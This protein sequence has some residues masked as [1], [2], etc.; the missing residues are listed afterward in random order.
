MKKWAFLGVI[1]HTGGTWTVFENLRAGLAQHGIELRWVVAGQR[2]FN[3]LHG[4][5]VGNAGEVVAMDERDERKIAQQL[6]THLQTKYDGTI[7]NVLCDRLCINV[8]QYLPASFRR[9]MLVHNITVGTYKAARSIRDYV[10]GS[11]GVSQRITDDLIQKY[12][13]NPAHTFTIHNAVPVERFDTKP[14]RQSRRL[15]I[16]VLSRIENQSKGSFHIPRILQQLKQLH[17][18]YTCT[19]IGD[20]P[21]LSELKRRC[22]GLKVHFTGRIPSHRV[23]HAVA[24]HDV[25]LFPSIYEGF[26]LSLIE[27]MAGG[28]V[29]VASLLNGVTD[30]I[31]TNRKSGFLISPSDT[32]GFAHALKALFEQPDLKKQMSC[33]AQTRIRE[34][35][36]V[37]AISARFSDLI[38]KVDQS[39]RQL[40]GTIKSL[41]HWCYSRGLRTGLRSMFPESFK[42]HLRLLREKFFWLSYS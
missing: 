28:C 8:I 18:P 23:P 27:A 17:V 6:A 35:F 30:E 38:D 32:H 11:I 31:V 37:N 15:R 26:G 21:D 10:H 22:A 39:P 16:L 40:P 9:L 13:F 42:S 20:G 29:P 36:S 7:V 25:Y 33:E 24:S 5:P 19:V 3:G 4:G 2:A 14:S 12:G 41:D 34:H 1:P